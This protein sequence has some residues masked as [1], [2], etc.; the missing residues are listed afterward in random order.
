M[1]H[2]LHKRKGDKFYELK[3]KYRRTVKKTSDLEAIVMDYQRNRPTPN[4]T[5]ND[6]YYRQQLNFISF[7]VHVLSDE[8]SIFYMYDK[9]VAQKGA[10]DVCSQCL[11]IMF[12]K[13]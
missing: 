8:S 1:E 3:R 4:V 13:F 9:T 7:N 12:S 5:T 6:V 10:D 11:N 2:E